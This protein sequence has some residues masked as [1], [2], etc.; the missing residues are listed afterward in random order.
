VFVNATMITPGLS[1]AAQWPR[2]ARPKPRSTPAGATVTM[3][4]SLLFRS[5][6]PEQLKHLAVEQMPAE[7][8]VLN[9]GP[10]AVEY[11]E[12]ATKIP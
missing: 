8:L 5:S 4:K 1:R 3:S 12:R 7:L 9:V 6:S 2:A 10:V 11:A